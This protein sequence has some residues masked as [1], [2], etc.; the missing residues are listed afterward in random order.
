MHLHKMLPLAS[1]MM[2]AKMS[3]DMNVKS[4]NSRSVKNQKNAN[5]KNMNAQSVNMK[6]RMLVKLVKIYVK[7]CETSTAF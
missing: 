4:E 5:V 2:L 6:D 1:A 3:V 7:M